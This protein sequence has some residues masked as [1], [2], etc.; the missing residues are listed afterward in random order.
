MKTHCINECFSEFIHSYTKCRSLCVSDMSMCDMM[1]VCVCVCVWCV[2]GVDIPFPGGSR[3]PSLSLHLQP[4]S[5]Q[6][7]TPYHFP[8]SVVC[9]E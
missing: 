5:R 8:Y 3:S 2:C 9:I 6:D 4:E 1:C 7:P